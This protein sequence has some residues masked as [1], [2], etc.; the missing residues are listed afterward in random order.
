[1]TEAK[2]VG[3]ALRELRLER[4]LTYRQLAY[5]LKVSHPFVFDLEKGRRRIPPH[6]MVELA[7][8]LGTTPQYLEGLAVVGD[9]PAWLRDRP[10]AVRLLK[11]IL[12]LRHRPP[13]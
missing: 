8:A 1:M 12:S 10:E 5:Q 2:T 11:H 3:E 7:R 4:G 13:P 6:R 9:M